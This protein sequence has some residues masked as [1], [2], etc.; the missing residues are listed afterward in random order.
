MAPPAP[1]T[2]SITTGWPRKPRIDSARTRPSV[3]VGPPAGYGTTI[4]IGRDG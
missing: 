3:S 4:V 1:L 2:F